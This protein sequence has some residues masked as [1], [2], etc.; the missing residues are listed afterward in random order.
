[1][2]RVYGGCRVNLQSVVVVRRIFKE[3]IGWVEYLMRKQ[4]EKLPVYSQLTM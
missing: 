2:V 3:T 1:V 4:E